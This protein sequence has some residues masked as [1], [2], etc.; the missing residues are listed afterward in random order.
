MNSSLTRTRLR[1]GVVAVALLGLAACGGI[2]DDAPTDADATAFCEAYY[3]ESATA[4]E[5]ADELATIGTPSDISDEER[6]G[7]EVYVE[8]LQDEGDRP[9]VDVSEVQIPADDRADGTAFV[10]YASNLCTPLL[11][12]TDP[13]DPSDPSDPAESTEPAEE[14]TEPESEEP[15]ESESEPAEPSGSTTP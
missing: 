6:N 2:A 11:T 4:E 7:F 5:V 3:D 14:P 15:E 10:E 8:G 13:V 1:A 12:P 9:N